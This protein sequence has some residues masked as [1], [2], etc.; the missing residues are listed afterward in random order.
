MDAGASLGA[1]IAAAAGGLIGTPWAEHGRAVSN[2]TECFVTYVTACH[3][4]D[5][6]GGLDC[7]GHVLEAV[8]RGTGRSIPDPRVAGWACWRGIVRVLYANERVEPGDLAIA[9]AHPPYDKIDHVGIV[10]A[11]RRSVWHAARGVGVVRSGFQA[12]RFCGYRR[13]RPEAFVA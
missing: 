12:G 8:H 13:F 4:R 5:V 9:R 3:E 7:L 10:A 6:T 11:D 2:V 1:R